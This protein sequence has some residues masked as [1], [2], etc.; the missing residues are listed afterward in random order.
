[1]GCEEL[2]LV[3]STGVYRSMAQIANFM[4]CN[5]QMNSNLGTCFSI[6]S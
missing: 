5:L 6:L 2:Y 3:L 1:M 4:F